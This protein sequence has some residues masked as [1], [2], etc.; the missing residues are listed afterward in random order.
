MSPFSSLKTSWISNVH[1]KNRRISFATFL[2]RYL[3]FRSH[4][5]VKVNVGQI[6][7]VILH[8]RRREFS[9]LLQGV[10]ECVAS[11]R[12]VPMYPNVIPRHPNHE[13]SKLFWRQRIRI[14]YLYSTY[15]F[16][17]KIFCIMNFC[18][19]DRHSLS[20]IFVKCLCYE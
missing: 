10:G 20:L 13:L 14:G 7:D 16:C 12:V 2:L 15:N 6:V 18:I 8:L 5:E 1:K 17:I 9:V 19:M 4:I 11:V 3:F